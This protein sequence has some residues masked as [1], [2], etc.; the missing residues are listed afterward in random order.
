MILFYPR[1]KY[2]QCN[3]DQFQLRFISSLNF[4]ATY[5]TA[6]TLVRKETTPEKRRKSSRSLFI[7]LPIATSVF[8]SPTT[9]LRYI[10]LFIPFW[11][12]R[13]NAR[14]DRAYT[15]TV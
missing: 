10:L 2:K 12:A 11:R 3:V 13:E 15:P 14:R 1:H 4:R 8:F 6:C 9:H 7:P 5:N